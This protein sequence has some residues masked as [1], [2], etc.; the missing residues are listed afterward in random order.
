LL[1][2]SEKVVDSAT[3]SHIALADIKAI[4]RV[5]LVDDEQLVRASTADMLTDLGYEVIEA[6]SASKALTYLDRDPEV[7]GVITDHL[8]PD[9]TGIELARV[10]AKRALGTPVLIISGYAE[11]EGIASAQPLLA[12]PFRQSDLAVSL[13]DLFRLSRGIR[14]ERSTV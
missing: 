1:P 14:G 3:G 5:L 10:I 11:A 9:M 8:M 6:S 4:G 2:V 7:S 13:A 12:N